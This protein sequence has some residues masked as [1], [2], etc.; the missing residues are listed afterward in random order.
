MLV[1]PTA[2]YMLGLLEFLMAAYSLKEPSL[3]ELFR[4]PGSQI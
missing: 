2:Y 4:E 1:F 3:M